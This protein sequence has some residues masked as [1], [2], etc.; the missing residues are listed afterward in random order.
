MSK[1]KVI[2]AAICL[3]AAAGGAMAFKAQR[4]AVFYW[5]GATYQPTNVPIAC[6]P[7]NLNCTTTTAQ[8]GPAVTLYTTLAPGVYSTIKRAS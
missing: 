7:G 4:V 3:L 5:D 8:G 1:P 6:Q 2:L